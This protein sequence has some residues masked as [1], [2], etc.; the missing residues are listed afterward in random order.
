LQPQ[1]DNTLATG[2]KWQNVLFNLTA[3]GF[4]AGVLSAYS[5]KRKKNCEACGRILD[6]DV[7]HLRLGNP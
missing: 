7:L 4:Q 5:L 3:V 6:Y 1:V 2:S